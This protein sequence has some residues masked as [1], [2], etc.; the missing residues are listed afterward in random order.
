MNRESR[1]VVRGGDVRPAW[2]F[3]IEV[4]RFVPERVVERVA[5]KDAA[6]AEA[7]VHANA[8]GVCCVLLAQRAGDQLVDDFYCWFSADR[9]FLRRDEHREWYATDL[10]MA[11]ADG[12]V[13][14]RDEH[15]P[16]PEPLSQTVSRSQA[17]EA[18]AYWLRTG[19]LL[20]TLTWK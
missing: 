7:I 9:A 18:V 1:S 12:E 8:G 15:G 13:E 2:S 17:F 11:A 10:A 19:E 20:P 4:T 3:D 6:E 5:A 14:F 16:V